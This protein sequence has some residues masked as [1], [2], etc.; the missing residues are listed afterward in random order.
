[1][2]SSRCLKRVSQRVFKCL[3]Y[4]SESDWINSSDSKISSLSSSTWLVDTMF[5]ERLSKIW[6]TLISE[7]QDDVADELS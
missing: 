7:S 3:I 4:G 6:P 5:T 1:M 2:G